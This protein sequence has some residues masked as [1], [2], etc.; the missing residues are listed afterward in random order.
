VNVL[1]DL[2]R[3]QVKCIHKRKVNRCRICRIAFDGKLR[4]EVQAFTKCTG[5]TEA[6]LEIVYSELRRQETRS[7]R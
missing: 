6:I 7:D 1:S 2:F 5:T 3:T 4:E